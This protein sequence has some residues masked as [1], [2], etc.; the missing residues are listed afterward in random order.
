VGDVFHVVPA[1]TKRVKEL[2]ANKV[3]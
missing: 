2:N 3:C 1:I